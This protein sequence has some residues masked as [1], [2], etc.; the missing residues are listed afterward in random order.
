MANLHQTKTLPRKKLDAYDTPSKAVF[1]LIF[2]LP[3]GVHY[4]EPCAGQGELVLALSAAGHECVDAYDLVPRSNFIRQ[5]D[6]FT[7][8]PAGT[9]ITNPP[10]NLFGRLL[11]HWLFD[12]FDVEEVWL[13]HPAPRLFNLDFADLSGHLTDIVPIGRVIWINGTKN[14]GYVD[15]V[16]SRFTPKVSP[17]VRF[18]KR[19]KT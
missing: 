7:E 17:S 4:V 1:P 2:A 13:L 11:R 19:I 3:S 12:C 14:G 8:Y 9:V 16:W 6:A 10:F 18:H 5:A 15:H